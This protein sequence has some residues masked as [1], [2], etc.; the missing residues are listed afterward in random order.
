MGQTTPQRSLQAEGPWAGSPSHVLR[1]GCFLV[2][3]SRYR[4]ACPEP[5]IPPW[6]IWP[7]VRRKISSWLISGAG[8]VLARDGGGGWGEGK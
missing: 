3:S 2:V 4:G 6:P 1:H 7:C 8:T 5:M